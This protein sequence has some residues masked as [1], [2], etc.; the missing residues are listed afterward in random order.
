ML[1]AYV[2]S[3]I[4]VLLAASLLA[5]GCLVASK[6]SQSEWRVRLPAYFILLNLLGIILVRLLPRP[7]NRVFFYMNPCLAFSSGFFNAL[8]RALY[9]NG[10]L[11][12]AA[13]GLIVVLGELGLS[14]LLW[15]GAGRGLGAMVDNRRPSIDDEL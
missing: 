1:D 9:D 12:G 5:A 3:R 13:C 7:F 15:L 10:V 14:S 8:C 6:F 4:Q 11:R 2:I